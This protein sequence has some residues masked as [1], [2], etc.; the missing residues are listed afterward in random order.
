MTDI[1]DIGAG[2]GERL[3]GWPRGVEAVTAGMLDEGA[4]RYLAR[5]DE[6]DG[7][8]ARV[9]DTMPFNF[10]HL[11]LIELMFPRARV[12]HCVRHPLDLALQCFFKNFAGRSLSFAF[13][14]G[15]IKRYLC[16]Y[17][18]LMTHWHEVCTLSIHVLRYESLVTDMEAEARKLVAFAGLRWSD[19]CTRFYQEGVATSEADTPIREPLDDREVG[20]WMHYREHLAPLRDALGVTEYEHGEF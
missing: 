19:L 8:A 2:I 5:L 7:R 6:A 14:L 16:C 12:V 18:S 4:R 3:G 20:G 13:D 11:G 17:R 1:A 15:D 10:L 9:T